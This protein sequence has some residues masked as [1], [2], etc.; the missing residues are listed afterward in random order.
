MATTGLLAR[1]RSILTTPTTEWPAIAGESATTQGLYLRYIAPLSA[2]P[3]VTEFLRGS[4]LGIGI[5][6]VATARVDIGAGLANMV[7]SYLVGL[8][9]IYV[10]ALSV[11]FLAPRFGGESD[12]LQALKTVAYSC[13]AAWA[14]SVGQ[15]LPWI[16]GFVA[17]AGG[18]YSIYLLYLGLPAVM[19]C[20]KVKATGYTVAAVVAAVLVGILLSA[21]SGIFG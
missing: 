21:L 17:L 9:A 3:P 8:I 16:G 20:P 7:V 1:V 2:I 5:P 10:L 6:G 14:A 18:I 19:K 15:L 12:R 11:D 4:V 13:T